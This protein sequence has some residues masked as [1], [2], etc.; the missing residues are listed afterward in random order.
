MEGFFKAKMWTM[1][2]DKFR[3]PLALSKVHSRPS[4]GVNQLPG[5]GL[6]PLNKGETP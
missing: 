4:C 2:G 3:V 1:S 6:P 5:R